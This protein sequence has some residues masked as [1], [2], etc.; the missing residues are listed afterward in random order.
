MSLSVPRQAGFALVAALLAAGFLS[1][2]AHAQSGEAPPASDG[3]KF[4]LGAGVINKPKFAGSDE[5]E[6]KALPLIGAS[7]G[8][9]FF[10]G[11]PGAGVPAGIG[12]FLVQDPTWRL[13]V[14]VGGGLGKPREESDDARLAGLGDIDNTVRGSLFGGYSQQGFQANASVSTDLGG[15]DQGTLVTLDLEATLP[16]SQ[17]LKLSA[18]PGL[19]WADQKYNQAYFGIN[20]EQSARSGRA[21][22]TP[23]AGL[24]TLRFSLGADYGL[25]PQWSISARAALVSLRG[26]AADS[27][28][29]F[30]KMQNTFGLL[31]AYRF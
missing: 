11:V 30:R 15:K 24:H 1:Q 18:G 29:A 22:Y 2:P 19:S 27:P 28:L 8:R 23:D 10:G 4:T 5:R 13:G 16:V 21:Q 3:W 31:T 14:A 7:Y 17:R 25:T 12:A 20:A 9:F 26:D 6:F